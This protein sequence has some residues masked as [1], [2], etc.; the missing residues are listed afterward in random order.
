M[1]KLPEPQHYE[2]YNWKSLNEFKIEMSL[3]VADLPLYFTSYLDG[4]LTRP[5]KCDCQLTVLMRN[6]CQ[7]R[8]I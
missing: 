6:G 5:A 1:E 7:C 3:P 4:I 8:G 2:W